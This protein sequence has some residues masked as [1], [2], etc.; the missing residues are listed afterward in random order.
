MY[1]TPTQ[2]GGGGFGAPALGA[3]LYPVGAWIVANIM[4]RAA[5][6]LE[7]RR[8]IPWGGR[9]YVLEPR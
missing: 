3:L 5:R 4:R 9:E 2:H 8:P 6:D 1:G 7:R